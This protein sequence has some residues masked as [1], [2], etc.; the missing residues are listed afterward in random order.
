[1]TVPPPTDDDDVLEFSEASTFDED[2]WREYAVHVVGYRAEWVDR[3]LENQGVTAL[4]RE[5]GS[6]PE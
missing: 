2:F 4:V 1:M 6:P 3:L 5:L